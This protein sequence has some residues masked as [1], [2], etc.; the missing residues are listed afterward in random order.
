MGGSPSP[1][2]DLACLILVLSHTFAQRGI[3]AGD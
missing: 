3:A 2:V 1:V